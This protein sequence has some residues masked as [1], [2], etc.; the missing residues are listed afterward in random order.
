MRQ[1]FVNLIDNAVKYSPDG[2]VI[3]IE[4]LKTQTHGIITIQDS[5]IGVAEKDIPHLT[6]RFYCT[7][8]VADKNFEGHRLGL[9]LV[10]KIIT[11]HGDT[12]DIQSELGVGTKITITLPLP[13]A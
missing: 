7:E 11:L 3:E 9:S 4:L 6:E 5:G 2:G 8:T 12:L 10:Q 13:E 1:A